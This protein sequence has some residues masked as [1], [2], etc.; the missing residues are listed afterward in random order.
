[1]TQVRRYMDKWGKLVIL[2]REGV[3]WGR[4]DQELA[5]SIQLVLWMRVRP[6]HWKESNAATTAV[7]AVPPAQRAQPEGVWGKDGSGD[8]WT[9]RVTSRGSHHWEKKYLNGLQGN[10]VD[11]KGG[12]QSSQIW[13]RHVKTWH[14]LLTQGSFSTK[15][16][17]EGCGV[18]RTE[19]W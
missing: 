18:P 4:D 6:Q 1:M 3:K 10:M 19:L 16:S 17:V 14:D 2:E 7:R 13:R 5:G 8:P 15:K 12:I 9:S 11:L